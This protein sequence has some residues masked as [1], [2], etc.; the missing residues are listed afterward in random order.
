M[1]EIRPT[2]AGVPTALIDGRYLH[3][4]RDPLKEASRTVEQLVRRDPACVVVLGFG[5][6][7]QTEALLAG[8]PT[9]HVIVFEP[10]QDLAA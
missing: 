10:D 9:T 7:Y 8:T 5:L 2:D 6:G 3:S 1:V 4:P